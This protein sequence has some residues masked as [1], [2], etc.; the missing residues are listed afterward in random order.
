MN[1]TAKALEKALYATIEQAGPPDRDWFANF[2]YYLKEHTRR[3]MFIEQFSFSV[4]TKAAITQIAAFVGGC[5]LDIGAGTGI[6]SKLI[7]MHGVHVHAIDNCQWKGTVSFEFGKWYPVERITGIKAVRK[8]RSDALM[9]CW[10]PYATSMATGVLKAFTGSRL[11]YIGEGSGGCTGDE[12][13]HR[14][15]ETEWK[16]VDTISIP[17]WPG[18]HDYVMLYRR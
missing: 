1:T 16:E 15:L 13:F 4:P 9:L 6:W 8:Y 18:I 14:M 12:A 17:Q 11:V 5:M 3:D 10:P 7:S 2:H